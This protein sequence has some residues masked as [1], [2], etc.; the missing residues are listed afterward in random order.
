MSCLFVI[1]E[2]NRETENKE[3]RDIS[4]VES[5]MNWW[6]S[7]FITVCPK[8]IFSNFIFILANTG[9][10]LGKYYFLSRLRE[11]TI[12]VQFLCKGSL[13]VWPAELK[14]L[15]KWYSIQC[16]IIFYIKC[17]LLF[18][19]PYFPSFYGIIV[20][21]CLLCFRHKGAPTFCCSLT[22]ACH[23]ISLYKTKESLSVCLSVLMCWCVGQISLHIRLRLTWDSQHGCC[24]V[25]GCAT[26]HLFGL[27]WY[28]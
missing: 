24:L 8:V 2:A 28:R 23:C 22:D 21:T 17:V 25:Q 5:H 3:K 7:S 19:F 10:G 20:L 18:D 27:R 14:W 12:I 16:Y 6:P 9:L 1:V 4:K 13:L 11:G 26:S 15:H